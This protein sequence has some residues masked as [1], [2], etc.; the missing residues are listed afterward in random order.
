MQ[1][2]FAIF[3]VAVILLSLNLS[4]SD[5]VRVVDGDI[6]VIGADVYRLH[7]IDVPEIAQNCIKSGKKKGKVRKNY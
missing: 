2:T 1:H 4:A 6:L 7:G 3:A 5:A